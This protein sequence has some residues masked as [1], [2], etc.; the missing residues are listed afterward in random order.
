VSQSLVPAIHNKDP[1]SAALCGTEQKLAALIHTIN[2]GFSE[3]M[4]SVSTRKKTGEHQE[5]KLLA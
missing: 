2:V 1:T 4:F 3:S 5:E